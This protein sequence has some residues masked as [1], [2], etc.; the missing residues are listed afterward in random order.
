MPVGR[1]LDIDRNQLRALEARLK[2]ERLTPAVKA[3]LR[4]AAPAVITEVR[5]LIEPARDTGQTAGSIVSDAKGS[6]LSTVGV[7]IYSP[8]V[9]AAVLESGRRPGGRMP[10]LTA[11][12]AWAGRKLGD[13]RLA[14]VI[15]RAIAR[16]GS[17]KRRRGG[18]VDP[19]H[20]FEQAA[21]SEGA[22]VRDR[23]LAKIKAA[24]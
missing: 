17:P 5:R 22:K 1:R 2:I 13:E 23:I 16:D 11:L 18:S 6:N 20:Q 19:Y 3:G 4:D 9:S 21:Q 15:A 14:F 8:M 12:R 10:P 7:R 24:L